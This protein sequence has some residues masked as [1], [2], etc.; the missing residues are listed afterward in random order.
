M[1]R[2]VG[3]GAV[4]VQHQHAIGGWRYRCG[5]DRQTVPID[6]TVIEQKIVVT[7]RGCERDAF[8]RGVAF[9]DG[10]RVVVLIGDGHREGCFHERTHGVGGPDGQCRDAALVRG[11]VERQRARGAVD[12]G[13]VEEAGVRVQRDE[14]HEIAVVV[15]E[16]VKGG[17]QIDDGIRGVFPYRDRSDTNRGRCAVRE[18]RGNGPRLVHGYGQEGI[19][20]IGRPDVAGPGDEVISYVGRGGDCH[21]GVRIEP[22][23]THVHAAVCPGRGVQPVLCPP[24]PGD[25]RV[26]RDGEGA[27]I[28]RRAARGH[29]AGAGPAGGDVLS[30]AVDDR[31]IRNESGNQG[32]VAV[33]MVTHAGVRRAVRRSYCECMQMFKRGGCG[34]GNAF[35]AL[36]RRGGYVVE[37]LAV[38]HVPRPFIDLAC[39]VAAHHRAVVQVCGHRTQAGVGDDKIEAGDVVRAERVADL[40]TDVHGLP[41]HGL[42]D[43]AAARIGRVIDVQGVDGNDGRRGQPGLGWVVQAVVQ[44]LEAQAR[45]RRGDLQPDL[46]AGGNSG[47]GCHASD[48]VQAVDGA[49]DHGKCRF[50]QGGEWGPVR[51]H[52]GGQA[53]REGRCAGAH[54]NIDGHGDDPV[55]RQREIIG[56]DRDLGEKLGRMRQGVFLGAEGDQGI[57][58]RRVLGRD[59]VG[60]PSGGRDADLVDVAGE[61]EGGI[62]IGEVE[63]VGVAGDRAGITARVYRHAVEVHGGIA[64]ALVT[65]RTVL[66]GI[67]CE[68]VVGR[69]HDR[70]VA[71]IEGEVV[72]AIA[73]TEVIRGLVPPQSLLHHPVPLPGVLRGADPERDR[74][75]AL[76]VQAV[77]VGHLDP[78]PGAA[79][80]LPAVDAAALAGGRYVVVS[81][82]RQPA[83]VPIQADLARPRLVFRQVP[84]ADIV[85]VPDGSRV[86]PA[87]GVVIAVVHPDEVVAGRTVDPGHTHP[88]IRRP[89]LVPFLDLVGQR[90]QVTVEET[91]V[92]AEIPGDSVVHPITG[93][94]Y[95]HREVGEGF[96]TCAVVEGQLA[97][98]L[99]S[100]DRGGLGGGVARSDRIDPVQFLSWT[101]QVKRLQG[102]GNRLEECVDSVIAGHIHKCVGLQHADGGSI[103]F[104]VGNLVGGVRGD[105]EAD[106]TAVGDDHRNRG[107]D[108][109][110][111]PGT[112]G[113]GKGVDGKGRGHRPGLVHRDR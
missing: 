38:R 110:I 93:E 19:A 109:A 71:E 48:P 60:A 55:R 104:H 63:N 13:G 97:P 86:L 80:G 47:V 30:R 4:R 54:V 83:R 58:L 39:G 59:P 37:S 77:M 79:E 89:A 90:G 33:R 43:D 21:I 82:I 36:V 85:R 18:G 61:V 106:G 22:A 74:H 25:G 94:G 3:E 26:V 113:N 105:D 101:T 78:V 17:E 40:R 29:A 99:P 5:V 56:H 57:I 41:R 53:K 24:G 51:G 34:I 27:R 52:R 102:A 7:Q 46:L 1:V 11:I 28:G 66:P 92:L 72:G 75:G 70:G 42:G 81:V 91:Q 69:V 15:L 65:H 111:G 98:V 16:V 35:R 95:Q 96:G 2:G 49:A 100:Q 8:H 10:H 84:D 103:H 50:A 67:G 108:V 73:A 76:Q 6:I 44:D 112:G 23:V 88:D 62:R 68:H 32:A 9:A 87:G 31:G 14:V 64:A 45:F 20:G 12:G 107:G